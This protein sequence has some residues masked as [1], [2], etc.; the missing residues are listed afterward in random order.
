MLG[1]G[2][3]LFHGAKEG[4]VSFAFLLGLETEG[5]STRHSSEHDF[6]LP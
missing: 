4:S 6:C 5:G 1:W 3:L 2:Q